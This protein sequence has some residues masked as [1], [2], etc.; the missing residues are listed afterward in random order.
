MRESIANGAQRLLE[1]VSF[2][3]TTAGGRTVLCTDCSLVQVGQMIP[4]NVT[5]PPELCGTLVGQAELE[6]SGCCHGIQCFQS[7]IVPQ[8]VQD[9]SISLPQELEPGCDMLT[10][11]AIL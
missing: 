8:D 6:S 4:Q 3:D 2:E 5:Q 1:A 7:G 10:V 9:S 11:N